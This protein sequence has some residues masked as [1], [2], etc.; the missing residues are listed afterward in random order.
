VPWRGQHCPIRGVRTTYEMAD[1]ERA[2]T[3]NPTR[4]ASV[5]F[6][7]SE[8]IAGHAVTMIAT[9]AETSATVASFDTP[10]YAQAPA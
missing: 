8:S 6:P 4:P 1:S 10:Q 2:T 3:T 5:P 7:N 9:E